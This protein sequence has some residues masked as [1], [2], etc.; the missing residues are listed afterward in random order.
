MSAVAA[1]PAHPQPRAGACSSSDLPARPAPGLLLFGGA[2]S[3]PSPAR[4]LGSARPLSPWGLRNPAPQEEEEDWP[5]RTGKWPTALCCR[6]TQVLGW[7]L[8]RQ[9]SCVGSRRWVLRGELVS[10]RNAE[11][12][13]EVSHYIPVGIC[14]LM[15]VRST[16]NF[17]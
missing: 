15:V 5:S 9:V 16:G 2:N 7:K 1:G 17:N 6:G 12:V 13:F 3:P 4:L 11:L 8:D 10:V 14:F